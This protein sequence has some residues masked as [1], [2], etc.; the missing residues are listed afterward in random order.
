MPEAVSRFMN[1]NTDRRTRLMAVV[2]LV[3]HAGMVLSACGDG[4]SGAAAAAETASEG[5]TGNV[6]GDEL[7]PSTAEVGSGTPAATLSPDAVPDIELEL[8]GNENFTKGQL[9]NLH[10]FAGK[11]VVLNFWF[12]S[13][14]PC[15]LEMPDLEESW[16]AH[17]EDGVQFVGVQQL[18]LDSVQDGQDFIDENGITYA[19]GADKGT[20]TV[21]DYSIRGFPTTLFLDAE[22]S[23]V[24][25]W[26]GLLN[27][28]KLEELVALLLE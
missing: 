18:S 1:A 2:G 24:A 19:I 16:Q 6:A 13:C 12:P 20:R 7:F 17:R 23:Q 26:D 11:P 4:D 3:V 27:F 22:L 5:S 15:R 21:V 28:E 10:D 9:V 14:P 8:L 25:R